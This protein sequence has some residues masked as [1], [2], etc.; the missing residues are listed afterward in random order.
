MLLNPDSYPTMRKVR[1]KLLSYDLESGFPNFQN[2]ARSLNISHQHLWRKLNNEGTS[3]QQIKDRLRYDIAVTYLG[4]PEFSMT[5]IT[6]KVGYL[7]K[8]HFYR[9]F[10]K[11]TGMPPGAYRE[12][13]KP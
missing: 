6:E 4:K 9:M 2:L 12:L 1:Q 5:E 13:L 10:K 3:Y 7:D 8:R 11:W